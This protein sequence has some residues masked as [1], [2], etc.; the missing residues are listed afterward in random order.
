MLLSNALS[1]IPMKGHYKS[2]VRKCRLC[3]ARHPHT[4]YID[5]RETKPTSALGCATH[6]F[7]TAITSGVW[8]VVYLMIWGRPLARE[9][10]ALKKAVY[11]CQVCGSAN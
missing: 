2:E 3:G 11:H 5:A 8:L 1:E 10:K 4:A 7:L 6:F 9:H